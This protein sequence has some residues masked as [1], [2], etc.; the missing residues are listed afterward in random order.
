MES[1]MTGSKTLDKALIVF[2]EVLKSRHGA[3]AKELSGSLNVPAATTYRL[4]TAFERFGLLRREPDGRV[5]PGA[6]LLETFQKSRYRK[7]LAD[8]GRPVVGKLSADSGTTC[9]LGTLKQDMVTYLIKAA[10]QGEDVLTRENEQLEA[11]CSG[12]GKVLLSGLSREA[13]E[14]YLANGP[15]PALT[16]NT[17]TDELELAREIGKTRRRGYG[18][19][20][21]E[22]D[23]DLYCLAVPVCNPQGEV[24]ASLS[25]SSHSPQLIRTNLKQRLSSLRAAAKLIASRLYGSERRHRRE[26]G[27]N[28]E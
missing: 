26:M 20:N 18:I 11:Y 5:F 17:I 2:T 3:T 27:L 6:A 8:V 7:L 15:F 24:V 1:A 28:E 14:A 9:H 19:D 4:L 23:N 25:M 12:I 16:Q 10:P 13:L 21:G 22:A